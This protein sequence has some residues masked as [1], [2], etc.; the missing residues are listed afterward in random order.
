MSV[1]EIDSG[2]KVRTPAQIAWARLKKN[3]VAMVSGSVA[4]FFILAAFLAPLITNLL[5]LTPTAQYSSGIA[6]T[7]IPIGSFGGLSL[8]HP[9]GLEPGVGRDLMALLLYGSRISFTVAII[10]S[11]A[12]IGLGM[13]I[14]IASGYFGGRVD[15]II[16]RFSDLVLSF[17]S[18]F[19]IIALSLPLTQRVEAAHIAR[20]NGARVVVLVVFFVIFGWPAFARLVRSQTLSIRERDFIMAA[21]AQGASGRRIIFKEILP[22]LWPTAIVF[23]SLSLPGFLAAEAVFSF[24]G[25]GVQA[26]SST[27]GLVLSDAVSY[28]QQ[29]PAYLLI[30]S[31]MLIIVV[32]S[33][34]LF[35]DG[36]RD[37]LDPK[38]DRA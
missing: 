30:P 37:A 8:K 7:G 9:L 31:G 3:K 33:L 5:N 20:D 10:T 23:L 16:G 21:K 34:N 24:L 22:N 27:W 18:T 35:G 4:L 1:A 11:V 38:S 19:M 36:L 17:P 15:A 28:W 26:P 29:D 25:V 12:S 14:G 6:D 13:V 2:V 32:L